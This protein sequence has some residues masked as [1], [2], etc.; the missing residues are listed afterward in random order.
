L[1]NVITPNFVLP[2]ATLWQRELV[3][4]WRQ[5]SRLLG[6][7]ASPL[8]IWLLIGYGSNSLG[9]FYSGAL[10]LTVMFSAIF[11]TI[12]IIEDRREGFLLSMM[13]SPAPRT[14]MVL[15]KILG[16]ATL[17]WIQGAIFLLFA[18]LAG[19]HLQL[20]ELLTVAGAIFLISF[21]LTG[22]GFVIAWKMESTAGFHAI[23]NLLLMPMWMVSGALFSLSEAHGW[24]KALMWINPLTYSL[25][26][27]NHTLELPNIMP[28]PGV[29]LAVTVAFG[30]ALL[31]V[32][33]MLAAQKSARS[34]A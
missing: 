21:T 22:L 11:S 2:A 4:F 18:P 31:L 33:G 9:R 3:R 7:I 20:G 8:V 10:V 34:A 6:V 1:I 27:L 24:V 30:L 16:A 19:F 13:V 26:L 32:C 29:S 5:K 28:G 17:A 25:S 12:S 14:S 23:M 15:G